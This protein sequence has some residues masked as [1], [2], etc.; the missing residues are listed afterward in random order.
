MVD[1]F[2]PTYSTL[3]STSETYSANEIP[4]WMSTAGRDIFENVS[5]LSKTPYPVYE[6]DRLA[7]YDTF[8]PAVGEN[9]SFI[10]DGNNKLTTSE[11]EGLGILGSLDDTFQPYLDEYNTARDGLGLG[12]GASTRE[13]LLGDPFSMDTA[14][15]FMDIYQ[16]AMNPAVREIQEQTIRSQMDA[17]ERAAMGGGSFGSRLGIMEGVASGEGAQAAGDLRAKAGREGLD[18]AAGRYD[19]DRTARFLAEDKMRMGYETD[20]ASRLGE[21]DA[22]QAAG[23]MATDLQAQTAQGLITAGEAERLL[24]QRA[25]DL[26]YADFLDQRDYPMEQLNAAS[27]ALSQTPYSTTSRGYDLSTTMAANPSVYGQALSALGT[28]VSAYNLLKP[29][30]P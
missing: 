13:E 18:F 26:A 1:I 27:A 8:N 24:D 3:P 30:T 7:N 19:T 14:Q 25:L 2:T 12:Y 6:G 9:G 21:M 20:E 4:T 10:T 15:P 29:K 22:I 16:D 28:G 23:N 11:Q 5:E 17:R